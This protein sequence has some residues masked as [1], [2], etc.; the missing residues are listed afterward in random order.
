MGMGGTSSSTPTPIPLHSQCILSVFLPLHLELHHRFV[1]STKNISDKS[2]VLA[3]WN[4]W[5]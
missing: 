5:K 3:S 1:S 2:S 4:L